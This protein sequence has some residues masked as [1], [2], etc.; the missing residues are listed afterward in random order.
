MSKRRVERR[1][2]EIASISDDGTRIVWKIRLRE[3]I[4][5]STGFE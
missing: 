3:V 4:L 2:A 1:K 5:L